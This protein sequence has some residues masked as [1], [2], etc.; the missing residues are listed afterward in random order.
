M[1]YQ[2]PANG[3]R[4][5]LIVWVTQGISA[6]GSTL[7]F[8]ALTIWL[9]TTVYARPE[10]KPELAAALAAISLAF[11]L[12]TILITPLAGAWADRH[13]RKRTMLAMDFTNGCL[14][15]LV[16]GL[17]IADALQFWMLLAATALLLVFCIG[18]LFNPYLLRVEDKPWLE[19]LAARAGGKT[20]SE[21]TT[22]V[23]PT[24]PAT[25]HMEQATR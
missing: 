11:A 5:F 22:Q 8:F 13:D 14:I 4:T 25:A 20:D 1:N 21:M 19:A 10:Q 9:T 7:T 24:E 2:P 23:A 6:F 18:Q 12:P 17:M 3:F 15:A 16:T